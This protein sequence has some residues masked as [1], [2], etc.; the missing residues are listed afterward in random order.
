MADTFRNFVGGKWVQSMTGKVFKDESPAERGSCIAAFQASDAPDIAA[1]VDRAWDAFAAW[2]KTPVEHRQA[3]AQGF[4][5]LLE[6][7]REPLAAVV[8]RENGKTIRESRGEID[9]ALAEG[10]YHAGQIRAF[11][12]QCVPVR[13]ASGEWVQFHPLGVA[14]IISPW[15]FPVNVMCRKT[16]PALLTGNTVV[17]KP[18]SYTPWSG[19]FMAELFERAGFPPGTFNCVTGAGSRAGNALVDDPRVRA[20]SFTGSTAVGKKI[21]A[22]AARHLQ[23]TQLELGGKNALIVMSDANVDEALEAA[24]TAGFACAGQWCTSTSRILVQA[25]LHDGFVERL[26]ERCASLHVGDPMDETVDMGPVAGET[27]YRNICAAIERAAAEGARLE[28]GGCLKSEPG[29]RGYYIRPTLFTGLTPDMWLFREE[30]FGP[31]LG[32]ARFETLDDALRL[33]NRSVYGLS[34][35]IFTRDEAVAREYVDRIEAGLAHVN[36]HTGFKKPALPFGGWKASGFGLPENGTTGLEFFVDRKAV[37]AHMPD[38]GRE[39]HNILTGSGI[40][41][42]SRNERRKNE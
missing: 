38:G 33:A 8:S 20:I 25:D 35:A 26:A 28:T 42:R 32:V 27:Q 31:V 7:N 24:V 9:S 13:P 19:V 23:R 37:Y 14:G 40:P 41:P 11:Y 16:L 2:R 18:A 3:L 5:A 15:N 39:T 30:V 17:F 6:E 4:L 34:S 21:L 12:G 36:L 1:A 22:G 29:D 10:A